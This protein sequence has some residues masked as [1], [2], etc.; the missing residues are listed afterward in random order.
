[1]RDWLI[2]IRK[3][4]GKSQKAVCEAACI[5]QPTY[6]GYEHG[7]YT[8]TVPVAKRIAE[9]LGFDWTRFFDEKDNDND[10][11]ESVEKAV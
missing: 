9:A 1:M 7:I 3:E 11:G 8:P 6:W 2:Q 5:S 10:Q 4:A